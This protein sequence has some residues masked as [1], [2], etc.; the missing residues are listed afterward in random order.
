MIGSSL[1]PFLVTVCRF[2]E[3]V[4]LC[5]A[6]F[7]CGLALTLLSN[8]LSVSPLPSSHDFIF[9]FMASF[10]NDTFVHILIVHIYIYASFLMLV[11]LNGSVLFFV[12]KGYKSERS[13]NEAPDV[14]EIE[15]RLALLDKNNNCGIPSSLMMGRQ[16]FCCC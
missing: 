6:I 14:C 7:C 10:G 1:W 4:L 11:L 5:F 15:K 12:L 2:G 8:V 13:Y 9:F 16:E 3:F